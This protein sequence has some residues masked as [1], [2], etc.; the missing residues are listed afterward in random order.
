MKWDNAQ[1]AAVMAKALQVAPGVADLDETQQA[2]FCGR[3]E[4]T[5]CPF[6]QAT[7]WL[8]EQALGRRKGDRYLAP[9]DVVAELRNIANANTAITDGPQ[10]QPMGLSEDAARDLPYVSA[11][12]AKLPE[13]SRLYRRAI[14]YAGEGRRGERSKIPWP[15]VDVVEKAYVEARE[16]ASRMV[17]AS[18]KNPFAKPGDMW[19]K[20]DKRKAHAI[21]ATRV[22]AWY[23]TQPK[24]DRVGGAA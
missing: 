2:A 13:A 1:K 15:P 16:K 9:G 14:G 23:A 10:G 7:A 6:P 24:Q 8:D 4:A 5:G 19:R 3:C 22:Y 12:F 18:P 21:I 17:P 11:M 20:W